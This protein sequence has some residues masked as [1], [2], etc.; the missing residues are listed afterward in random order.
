M[1]VETP[2]TQERERL[3]QFLNTDADRE[4]GEKVARGKVRKCGARAILGVHR[5][6]LRLWRGVVAGPKITGSSLWRFHPPAR[7]FSGR[8]G[9]PHF[10]LALLVQTAVVGAHFPDRL[11]SGV[12]GWR[13]LGTVG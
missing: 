12:S 10:S 8:G 7:L 5:I 4:S 9:L 1:R 2:S 6:L 3:I 13:Y 11:I